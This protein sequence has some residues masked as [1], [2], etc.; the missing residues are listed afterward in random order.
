V[1]LKSFLKENFD[2]LTPA[3]KKRVVLGALTGV[4]MIGASILYWNSDA[5]TDKPAE[6]PKKKTISLDPS[7]LEKSIYME[8]RE[9][10]KKR[11]EE[12]EAL[13]LQF[14][15]RTRELQEKLVSLKNGRQKPV[16]APVPPE[17][18]FIKKFPPPAEE[19]LQRKPLLRGEKSL[20]ESGFKENSVIG[21]IGYV[22]ATETEDLLDREKKV[23]KKEE[24]I[25]LPPSFMSATL[26][27]GLDAPVVESAK[28]N[29]MPVLLRIRN[30]AVLPNRVKANLKGCFVIAH[31]HGDLASERAYLRLVTLSCITKEGYSV[32]DQPVKGYISDSDGK[33]GLAGRVVSKMGTAIARAMFAGFFKGV[34]DVIESDATI[35]NIT[36][37]GG[38]TRTLEGGRIGQAG[39]G[40]GLQSGAREIQ[41]FYMELARQTM[42]VIEIGATRDVTLVVTQGVELKIRCIGGKRCEENY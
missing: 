33:I 13:K 37:L 20:A 16:V 26:L 9:A 14:E 36:A 11:D 6:T 3:A 21:G 19:P 2:E 29:P 34:G 12:M 23:K 8:N 7:I 4:F 41:K 39:V 17:P 10:I 42:P 27:S 24:S 5:N 15:A 28:G 40:K 18:G 22:A 35:T 1:G 30:L 38:T 25:Y 31:G 32:I